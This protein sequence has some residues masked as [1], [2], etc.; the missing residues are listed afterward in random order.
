MDKS[1]SVE[2]VH[3]MKVVE[4]KAEL[5]LRGL[6]PKGVKAVLVDRLVAVLGGVPTG[7]VGNGN[8]TSKDEDEGTNTNK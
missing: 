8:M 4:L 2:D 7:G 1:L 6:D 3:K 5:S